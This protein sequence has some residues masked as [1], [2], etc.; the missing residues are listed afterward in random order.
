MRHDVGV[1]QSQF[2]AACG[3]PLAVARYCGGCGTDSAYGGELGLDF[4]TDAVVD[5]LLA[6][7]S[8]VTNATDFQRIAP[9][10][11]QIRSERVEWW[12][13]L[14]AIFAFPIGLL[15]LL[16]KERMFCEVRIFVDDAGRPQL[17]VT[18]SANGAVRKRLKKLG[19]EFY[20]HYAAERA[21]A[22]LPA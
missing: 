3:R 20:R 15:A 13:V 11:L 19:R 21:A 10:R 6:G 9:G 14:I 22:P 5:W 12:A 2:C 8:G 17:A 18:G 4:D 1:S 16:V 7:L